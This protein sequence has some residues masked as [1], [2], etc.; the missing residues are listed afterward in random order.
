MPSY[1]SDLNKDGTSNATS[2]ATTGKGWTIFNNILKGAGMVGDTISGLRADLLGELS[3]DEI[4]ATAQA[5]QQQAANSRTIMYVAGGVLLIVLVLLF[6][7]TRSNE[8]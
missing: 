6:V 4:A 3:P 5:E 1:D 2:T 8:K 7:K